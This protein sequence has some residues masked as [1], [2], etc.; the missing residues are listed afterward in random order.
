MRAVHEGW[1]LS[2]WYGEIRVVKTMGPTSLWSQDLNTQ[3]VHRFFCFVVCL[4]FFFWTIQYYLEQGFL[5]KVKQT[6]TTKIQTKLPTW[7][8]SRYLVSPETSVWQPCVPKCS[9]SASCWRCATATNF[10]RA[11]CLPI[12][13][14]ILY[15]QP[16]G[17]I[18]AAFYCVSW[19]VTF[20]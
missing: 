16:W 6:T 1:G 20:R 12:F 9:T 8:K 14:M 7:E 17:L 11:Y 10:I 19:N 3:G 5:R 15:C 4:G 18:S 2:G 13:P